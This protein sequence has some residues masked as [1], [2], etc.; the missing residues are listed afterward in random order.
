MLNIMQ[1]KAILCL[2]LFSLTAT[3]DNWPQWRGPNADG[4]SSETGVPTT[5]SPTENVAWKVP[6]EGWGTSTPIVWD[7]QVFV[8]TQVGDGPIA[9]SNDFKGS[10]DA[11]R[12]EADGVRF[13]VKSFDRASGKLNWEKAYRA[14][15][16]LPEVHRKHNLASPSCVTDGEHVYAWFGSG[17]IVALTMQGDEVWRRNLAEENEA[18]DIRW[19]HGSS[20]TLYGDSLLLLVDH[21]DHAYLLA[22][23]KTTGKDL[24]KR[25]RGGDKRSYTT[26]FVVK[27]EQG[28]L[29]M[30]NTNV[31]LEA[32]NPANGETVWEVGEPNRVPVATP[33]HHG[34]VVYT[35]RG[36]NSSPYLAT[37]VDGDE[38]RV[39]WRVATGGPY[40]S[41]V[42]YTDGLLFMS[43]ESGIAGAVDAETG[44]SLWKTRL[45]GVFSASPVVADGKVYFTNE[46]GK[47][48]V[49]E[50]GRALKIVAENDLGERTL[51][52]PA[53]SGG[54]LFIRTDDHLYA[55]GG[56]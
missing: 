28:D 16:L 35:N 39:L 9:E 51:A 13:V 46:D 22:T 25:D 11:K 50:A 52:S 36:Y 20:P 14:D 12:M 6:L 33:V 1:P 37:R 42:I 10:K 54:L 44:K 18:F 17:L 8:T 45:G 40:V 7:E 19:G 29:L 27:R 31:S 3:A 4:V 55:I 49:V 21:P 23:D 56:K 48:T 47:T 26:P 34:G 41:S 32:L 5:W 30:V 2:L 53:I 43:N 15:D 24:W 38:P